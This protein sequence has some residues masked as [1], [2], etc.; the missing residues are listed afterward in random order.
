MEQVFFGLHNRSREVFG[1]HE[2]VAVRRFRKED[3]VEGTFDL[4]D[5][6]VTT[7]IHE[8]NVNVALS[9]GAWFRVVILDLEILQNGDILW[10]NQ[11]DKAEDLLLPFLLGSALR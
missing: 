7:S 6:K 9:S 8:R 10:E 5:V 2:I 1:W 4:Y 11:Q 3:V